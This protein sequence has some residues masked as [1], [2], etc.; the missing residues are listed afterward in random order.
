MILIGLKVFI[1]WKNLFE[2]L[3]SLIGPRIHKQDNKFRKAMCPQVTRNSQVSYIYLY[4]NS[5]IKLWIVFYDDI[6][7][8]KKK[9]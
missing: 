3:L 4:F 8:L 2:E 9:I 7:I 1:K 6:P 5:I